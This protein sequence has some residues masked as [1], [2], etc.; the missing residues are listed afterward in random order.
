M[1][2]ERVQRTSAIYS[3]EKHAQTGLFNVFQ[4][5][6]PV[7]AITSLTHRI[8]GV[9][10]AIGIP[11]SIYLLDLSRSGPR[12]FEQARSIFDNIFME[13]A[14]V[15][16]AWALGHHMLAGVRHLLSDVDIG[17]RLPAARRSAWAVNCISPLFAVLAAAVFI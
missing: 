10:L 9:A 2:I 15:L 7:G 1:E 14:M 16:F 6:L 3:G 13:L 4:I 5:Q 12:G 11:L 17:S 8:S